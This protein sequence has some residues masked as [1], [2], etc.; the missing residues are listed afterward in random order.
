MPAK[1]YD[2]DGSLPPI[3]FKADE[4][5]ILSAQ[6]GR[7]IIRFHNSRC[8]EIIEVAEH[9]Y[10]PCDWLNNKCPE[11]EE[12]DITNCPLTHC[13][14][15]TVDRYEGANKFLD[16]SDWDSLIKKAR[17]ALLD[18]NESPSRSPNW[19]R[20]DSTIFANS[21]WMFEKSHK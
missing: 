17:Y 14:Y 16:A 7:I 3:V 11:D 4:S 9:D 2:V 19:N 15:V 13:P 10:V 21:A 1:E 8:C 20:T 18:K 6:H 12:R 5:S